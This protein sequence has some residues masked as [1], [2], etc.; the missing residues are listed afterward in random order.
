M[1]IL[2]AGRNSGSSDGTAPWLGIQKAR[3]TEF[4]DEAHKWDW[5]EIYLTVELDVSGSDYS[6]PLKI[7]GSFEKNPD[8]TIQENSLVRRI[9]YLMTALGWDGGINQYGKWEDADGKE[10]EDAA[11]FFQSMYT[12]TPE[13]TYPYLV[14]VYKEL[15][16]KGKSYTRVHNKI[17]KNEGTNER[18]LKDHIAYLKKNGYLKEAV[19]KQDDMI[20]FDGDITELADLSLENL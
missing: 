14:Y 3:I 4:R 18:K 17:M 20:E 16:K 6:R 7:A 19:E 2:Q 11:A 12:N 1:A 5:A 8:G 10:L 9:N 13:G 15:P